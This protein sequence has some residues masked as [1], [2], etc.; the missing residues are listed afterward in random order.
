M[1]SFLREHKKTLAYSVSIVVK[2]AT[3][4]LFPILIITLPRGDTINCYGWRASSDRH[5]V[6]GIDSCFVIAEKINNDN[7]DYYIIRSEYLSLSQT[8]AYLYTF[9]VVICVCILDILLGKELNCLSPKIKSR[10][11]GVN[12]ILVIIILILDYLSYRYVSSSDE[13]ISSQDAFI[14]S[15]AT[16]TTAYFTQIFFSYLSVFFV[17]SQ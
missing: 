9:G 2:V 12:S 8:T 5:S 15:S 7:E 16:V 3:Y 17:S 10:L 11:D 4:F 14:G 1:L 13:E 6:Y